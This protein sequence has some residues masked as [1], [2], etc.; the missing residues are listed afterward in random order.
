MRHLPHDGF[1]WILHIVDHWS[2]FTF[3]FPLAQKSA[4]EV[5]SALEKWVFP[6]IG[7][8]SIVQSDNGREFVNKLI[9]E[10][11]ASWPGSVQL[12]SGRPRHP[13]FQGLVEQA[14]Y[15]LE[16]MLSA[17]IAE[18]GSKSPPWTRW[19]PHIVCKLEHLPNN[20]LI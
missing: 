14:H 17:K 19:L 6:F 1:K 11:V 5:T 18:C 10:V 4:K 9:E 3:A 16:R 13:Q 7:L 8:P 15:T 12:V 2:K 20:M